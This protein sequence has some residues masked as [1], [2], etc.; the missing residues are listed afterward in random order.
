MGSSSSAVM[1]FRVRSQVSKW[2]GGKTFSSHLI[3]TVLKGVEYSFCPQ[4]WYHCKSCRFQLS[5]SLCLQAACLGLREMHPGPAARV[6]SS[7]YVSM[8]TNTKTRNN[9]KTF[10]LSN[11]PQREPWRTESAL[12]A[13]FFCLV[14]HSGQ[15]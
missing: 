2:P 12:H 6:P 7:R 14:N 9:C 13:L 1:L 3:P 10:V 15:E 8:S 4:Q 5:S 11:R